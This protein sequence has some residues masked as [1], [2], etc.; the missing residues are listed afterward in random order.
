MAKKTYFCRK[1]DYMKDLSIIIPIYNVEK[2]IEDCLESVISQTFDNFECILVDDCSP[3]KSIDIAEKIIN[4]Y[5]GNIDFIILHHDYNRGLSAARNTG[6]K[7]STTN[8]V[9]FLDSD[10]RLF[11]NSIELLFNETR[12]HPEADIVSGE[13]FTEGDVSSYSN[14]PLS[15]CGEN[16]LFNY[17]LDSKIIPRAWNQLIRKNILIC[18]KLFFK[19][20]IIFEDVHWCYYFY[21]YVHT[22]YHVREHTYFYRTSNN[23]SIMRESSRDFDRPAK[24]YIIIIEDLIKDINYSL[25]PQSVVFILS[26]LMPVVYNANQKGVT[27]ETRN[28]LHTLKMNLLKKHIKEIRPLEVLY[29]INLFRP[30]SIFL[31]YGFYRHQILYKYGKLIKLYYRIF[32]FLYH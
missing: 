12:Q 29:E 8:Y 31:K 1:R 7:K 13:V 22:Y 14:I 21:R 26:K 6:L 10:D 11:S 2:Y 16:E 18:N 20:G 15:I 4:R 5:K 25:Y 27:D 23:N 9:Y 28:K 17:L 32:G 24:N 19:E 30:F 3:D